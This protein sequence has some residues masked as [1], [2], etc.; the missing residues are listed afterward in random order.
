MEVDTGRRRRLSFVVSY[1]LDMPTDLGVL[2]SMITP[3]VLISACAGLILSTSVRLGRVVDR[4]RALSEKFEEL[5][6]RTPADVVLYEER[7][8]LTFTQLDWLTSRA[9]YLQRAMTTFYLS[10]G[11]F[12]A[13]SVAIGISAAADGGHLSNLPVIFGMVGVG[14]LFLGTILLGFEATLALRSIHAEMDFLWMLGKHHA[15]KPLRDRLPSRRA[16]LERFR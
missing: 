10:L 6:Q 13:T 9:R 2:T 11:L 5:S 3:A 12:V 1:N 15:P 4:V 16:W 8:E 14:L 7:L